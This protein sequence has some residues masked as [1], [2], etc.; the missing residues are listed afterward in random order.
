MKVSIKNISEM[1]GFSP[2]TVCNA[3]NHK[4][5]V[6][7]N[8][9]AQIFKAAKELGYISEASVSK[10]KIIIYRK[11][12][13]VI[14]DSPFFSLVM[15]GADAA[16]KAAGLELVVVYLDK[17]NSDYQDQI[18]W[19][20]NDTTSGM[21]VMGS[22]LEEEELDRF[23]IAKCPVVLIDYWCND[24]SFN[25]LMAN[26][27][28]SMCKVVDYLVKKGHKKIGYL[29][30]KIRI[31]PFR[32]RSAAFRQILAQNNLQLP[33][34]Y[35][36]T[37]SHSMDGSYNDMAAYLKT[38]PLLPTAFFADNDVIAI[39]AMKALKEFGYRIPEDISLIGFDDLPFCEITS[40]KLTT[41]RTVKKE[42]GQMAVEKIID[43]V[44]N[45]DHIKT[46][47]EFSTTFIERDS[48][49]ELLH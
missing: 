12:G 31:Y 39:G 41:I 20:A 33:D 38:K 21:I 22:E 34:K 10:I 29:R 19:H 8:T 27:S 42:L 23:R 1:T 16:C 47:I 45:G 32:A 5:G 40:P 18:R 44:K 48:V 3:L 4:R 2:A 11:S 6:N 37:I 26:N 46:K 14:E 9:S 17:R 25:S 35:V 15:D 7:K 30:G 36:V 43:M 24:M 49:L 28:A 13:S